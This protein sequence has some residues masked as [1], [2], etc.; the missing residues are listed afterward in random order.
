M[1]EASRRKDVIADVRKKVGEQAAEAVGELRELV[2]QLH[3]QHRALARQIL[4]AEKAVDVA[5]AAR[6]HDRTHLGAQYDSVAAKC[7]RLAEQLE[8]VAARIGEER[9]HRLQLANEQR[10][11]V[12]AADRELRRSL[13]ASH[14]DIGARINRHERM[15][16]WQRLTWLVTGKATVTAVQRLD[17]MCD[18]PQGAVC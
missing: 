18:P 6:R 2:Q 12:D 11:Y 13:V 10:A 7:D 17:E 4:D 15:T 14:D 1:G 5:V 3:L 9:T 16:L 8:N